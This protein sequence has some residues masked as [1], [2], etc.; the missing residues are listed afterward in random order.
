MLSVAQTSARVQATLDMPTAEVRNAEAANALE[1]ATV[2]QAVTNIVQQL[3]WQRRGGCGYRCH[4]RSEYSGSYFF[5]VFHGLANPLNT[6]NVDECNSRRYM[7]SLRIALGRLGLPVAVIP[8]LQ[9]VINPNYRLQILPSLQIQRTCKNTSQGFLALYMLQHKGPTSDRSESGE[10][11][12][13]RFVRYKQNKLA[14]IKQLFLEEKVSH[15]DVDPSGA[16][17]LEVMSHEY[18]FGK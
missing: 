8:S 11:Y 15:L 7:L 5:W 9:L 16:T 14:E 3:C 6:C 13:A 4:C 10:Q 12:S 2:V 1:P 17:W 18:N